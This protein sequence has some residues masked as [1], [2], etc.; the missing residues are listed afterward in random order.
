MYYFRVEKP[1]E[2]ARIEEKINEIKPV[3]TNCKQ[4]E[5]DSQ[6]LN[7]MFIFLLFSICFIL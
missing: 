7:F 4:N 1:Q 6:K 5:L 2:Y 3:W